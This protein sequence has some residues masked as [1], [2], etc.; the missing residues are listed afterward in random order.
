[1]GENVFLDL[2]VFF[3]SGRIGNSVKRRF[4]KIKRLGTRT[5]SVF[6][7]PFRN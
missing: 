7:I 6:S 3:F 4:V 5:R 1:M 2:V